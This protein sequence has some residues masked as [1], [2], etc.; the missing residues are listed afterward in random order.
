MPKKQKDKSGSNE[1]P[2]AAAEEVA[3]PTPE[4]VPASTVVA[5]VAPPASPIATSGTTP[6]ASPAQA[7]SFDTL[8]T[9]RVS[10]ESRALDDKLGALKDQIQELRSSIKNFETELDARL[11]ACFKTI[12]AQKGS[13]AGVH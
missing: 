5:S 12:L 1:A 4:P 3:A 11:D 13:E 10:Q 8:Q 6:V 2:A 7:A 9:G